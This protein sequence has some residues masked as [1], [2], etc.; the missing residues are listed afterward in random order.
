M[1]D[2][3]PALKNQPATG[4]REPP[5]NGRPEGAGRHGRRTARL[6]RGVDTEGRGGDGGHAAAAAPT[7]RRAAA[8]ARAARAPQGRSGLRLRRE[9]PAGPRLPDGGGGGAARG[10][11]AP[12]HRAGRRCRHLGVIRTDHGPPPGSALRHAGTA[13]S[14]GAARV[15]V[16]PHGD[17]TRTRSLPPRVRQS[18]P[19]G[20]GAARHPSGGAVPSGRA[21]PAWRR[22]GGPAPARPAGRVR[23]VRHPGPGPTSGVRRSTATL[24]VRPTAR[25]RDRHPPRQ[26]RPTAGGAP[27][28]TRQ[29]GLAA[30]VRYSPGVLPNHLRNARWKPTA[31]W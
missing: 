23:P 30:C 29:A 31:L 25:I 22:P 24:P 21:G 20:G 11:V 2:R 6:S 7:H 8:G 9:R 10:G 27:P 14:V 15:V 3:P 1:N 13:G 4:R 5:R 26:A 17:T 12:P 18:S 16:S 19:R 28:P